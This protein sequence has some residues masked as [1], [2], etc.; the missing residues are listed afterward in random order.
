MTNSLLQE[1][2]L[3]PFK[4]IKNSHILPALKQQLAENQ[5]LINKLLRQKSFTWDNLMAP[6]EE[7]DCKLG[8]LWSPVSHLN[9]V[10]DTPK[11][12]KIYNQC[13]PLLTQHHIAISQNKQLYNAIKQIKASTDF[14]K[15]KPVQKRI[16]N[17]NLRDFELSGIHFTGKKKKRFA[18][19]QEQLVQLTTKF[20]ENVLDATHAWSFHA[21]RKAQLAGLPPHTIAL[22]KEKAKAAKQTGWLLGLDFPT[23]YAVMQFAEQ[24]SLRKIFYEAYCTRASDQGPHHK[25]FNNSQ[26]MQEIM[27]LRSELATMLGFKNFSELSLATKMAKNTKQ[28]LN[29]LNDLVDKSKPQAE[30]ELNALQR[31]A[32]KEFGIT[33]LQPWD[34]A[35]YSEKLRMKKFKISEEELRPY[36]PASTVMSGLFEVVKR[37]YNLR[38]EV[39][40]EAEVWHDDVNCFAIYNKQNRLIAYF[41][42]DLY[43]RQGK[44]GG[45]WMD[46]CRVRRIK[47]DGELQLPVAYLTCNFTPPVGKQQSLLTHDEVVTLFHEFG[48]CLHHMLTEINYAEVSGINEVPWDAVELPSQLM[49]NWCYQAEVIPLISK[50]FETGKPLPKRMLKQLL[51]AKNF[52][53]ALGMLRQLEFSLFDFELHCDFDSSK[54]QQ[55]IQNILT[56]V[57]QRVAVL[58][59]PIFNRFQ[60]SFSHIFAGG[61]AAGYYSYKWAEVLSSDVFACFEEEGIFNQETA[62]RF[63]KSFL[64]KGGSID[65]AK[66]FKKFRG[67]EPKVDNLLRHCGIAS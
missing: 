22:A 67:R 44:R 50:H 48:H 47:A 42:T 37:L 66:G 49:E 12:R 30:K 11:L 39:I 16:I 18:E 36:F 58:N 29:F 41:Y 2:T 34:F 6:L 19:I 14:K 45:A 21:K 43:A 17:N 56:A 64:S 26:I 32:K 65:A 25:K 52:Q 55:Q 9:S 59:P 33:E 28:V 54:D 61:Y 5:K 15:L 20:S 4:K 38:I 63:L 13:I 27:L 10:M 35:F 24:Q 40:Q 3:P 51:A 53:S 1:T 62:Q 60:N 23:Y 31:F 7:A 46:E 57:R 8:N